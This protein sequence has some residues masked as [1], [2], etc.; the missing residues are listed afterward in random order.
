MM[1]GE[2]E[3]MMKRLGLIA[4]MLV[5]LFAV[6]AFAMQGSAQDDAVPVLQTQVADLQTRVAALEA[7]S[8]TPVGVMNN[9]SYL[10]A[11]TGS[12]QTQSVV[13]AQ[14]LYQTS[15]SCDA[16]QDAAVAVMQNGLVARIISV[17][18]PSLSPSLYPGGETIFD[19]HC[20]GNWVLAVQF[21][22]F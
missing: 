19:V 1:R 6:G 7:A 4:G 11:D 2:K 12:K 14:G 18:G 20:D 3:G 9:A 10:F 13:L 8:T 16:S 22:G 17:G 15:F 21:V 5:L